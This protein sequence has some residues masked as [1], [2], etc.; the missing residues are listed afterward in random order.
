MFVVGTAGVL[1]ATSQSFGTVTTTSIPSNLVFKGVDSYTPQ[2]NVEGDITLSFFS[3]ENLDQN[4]SI[5]V[6]F[7]SQFDISITEGTESFTC[8]TNWYD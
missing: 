4:W 2:L 7:P 1:L 8:S 6:Y 5:G 3:P